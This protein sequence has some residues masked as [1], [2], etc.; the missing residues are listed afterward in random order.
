MAIRLESLTP[1]G[2]ITGQ[3]SPLVLE[4]FLYTFFY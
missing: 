2:D 1:E 4:E 3:Y